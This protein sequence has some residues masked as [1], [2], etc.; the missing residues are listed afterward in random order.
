MRRGDNGLEVS[1]RVYKIKGFQ[2]FAKSNLFPMEHL[3]NF[4]Y[5]SIKGIGM[6]PRIVDLWYHASDAYYQ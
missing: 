3:Q 6:G 2:K 5:I 1:S 4:C